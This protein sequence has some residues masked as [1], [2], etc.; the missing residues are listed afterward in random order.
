MPNSSVFLSHRGSS[1]EPDELS[2]SDVEQFVEAKAEHA[3]REQRRRS[4]EDF[5]WQETADR[6]DVLFVQFKQLWRDGRHGRSV[7]HRSLPLTGP[8][9]ADALDFWK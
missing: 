4:A 8:T 5:S 2:N 6:V 1:W 7:A 9:L 3:E